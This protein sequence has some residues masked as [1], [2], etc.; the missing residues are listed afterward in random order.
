MDV[1]T[2]TP[3]LFIQ[4]FPVGVDL[5]MTSP[6]MIPQHLLRARRGQGYPA[7]AD[8][9]QISYLIQHLAATQE[10]GIGFV[11][12]ILVGPPLLTHIL[13]TMGPSMVLNVPKC[14]SGAH[15][16]TRIW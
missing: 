9:D 3:E 1:K 13:E 10:G 6:P 7:H 11:W 2:I 12:D 5:I 8:V 4:A 14:G 16:P 15:R